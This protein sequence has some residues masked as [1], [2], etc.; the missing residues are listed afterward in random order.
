LPAISNLSSR[1][2]MA[3]AA[4]FRQQDI[5]GIVLTSVDE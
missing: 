4:S 5:P 3:K 1:T 2:Q